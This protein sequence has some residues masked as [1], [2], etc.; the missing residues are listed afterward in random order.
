MTGEHS[1][2]CAV[3]DAALLGKL[4]AEAE[5]SCARCGAKAHSKDSVCD[6]VPFEPDH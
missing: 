2:V 5:F 6:P 4:T 3:T 1:K